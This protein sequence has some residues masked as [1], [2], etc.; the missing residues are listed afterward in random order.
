M[1]GF[2]LPYL[3]QKSQLKVTIS[4]LKKSIAWYKKNNQIMSDILHENGIEYVMN[5]KKQNL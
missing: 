2:I 4:D 1:D 5:M 3:G